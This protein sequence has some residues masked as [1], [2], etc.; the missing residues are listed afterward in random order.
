[1]ELQLSFLIHGAHE[2]YS[3]LT[4]DNTWDSYETAIAVDIAT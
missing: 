1:M 3:L 4:V 2:Y